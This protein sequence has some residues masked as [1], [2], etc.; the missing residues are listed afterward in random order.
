MLFILAPR[1]SS[2]L[3]VGALIIALTLRVIG[4]KVRNISRSSQDR[5]ADVGAMVAEVLGAMK[6]V[7]AFNQQGRE[8]ERFGD[9][10]RSVFATAKR[11]ILI[12]AFM[13]PTE[14]AAGLTV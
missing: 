2:F 4:R 13:S 12:R 6:I 3:V 8:T 14:S 10:V 11:R 5:I 1:E 7:Q 9:A